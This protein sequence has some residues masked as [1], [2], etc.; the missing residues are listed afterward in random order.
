MS[1]QPENAIRAIT[2]RIEEAFPEF[3][4]SSRQRIRDYF[5]TRRRR[6]ETKRDVPY[7]TPDVRCNISS[8][9]LSQEFDS[10]SVE[11]L[12]RGYRQSAALLI[13]AA[14]ELEKL[15]SITNNKD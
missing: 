4:A 7:D 5:R 12:A 15:I 14:E 3:A 8:S 2:S 11:A 6:A 10:K 9:S 13:K 1:Q